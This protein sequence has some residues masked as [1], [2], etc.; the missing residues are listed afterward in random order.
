MYEIK[1]IQA[2]K[3]RLFMK[4]AIPFWCLFIII[5]TL[6]FNLLNFFFFQFLLIKDKKKHTDSTFHEHELVIYSLFCIG[7][8]VYSLSELVLMLSLNIDLN[9]FFQRLSITGLF[10]SLIAFIHFPGLLFEISKSKINRLFNRF[11]IILI[12][13]FI[14]INWVSL[15]ISKQTPTGG[16]IKG[17]E[18]SL[19]YFIMLFYIRLQPV[20]LSR[21]KQSAVKSL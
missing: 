17:T 20:T 19:Y 1:S 8:L 21:W 16:E 9:P 14:L 6:V 3:L 7:V 11:L 2:K 18:A 15:V 5:C 4:D 10:L 12:T 13:V